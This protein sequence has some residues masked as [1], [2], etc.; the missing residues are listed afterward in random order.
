[1]I[2]RHNRVCNYA[3]IFFTF[4]ILFKANNVYLT[5]ARTDV[6]SERTF[7][8][9]TSLLPQ[10][11][12]CCIENHGKYI[13][14]TNVF[15]M[16]ENFEWVCRLGCCDRRIKAGHVRVYESGPL[17]ACPQQP[18]GLSRKLDQQFASR[19]L[20]I[21]NLVAVGGEGRY[22]HSEARRLSFSSVWL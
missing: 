6:E 10:L 2:M 3:A 21:S 12:A 17:A 20:L 1:M 11:C 8:F 22:F 18:R 16:D 9:L 19:A 7:T 14:S 15:R 13:S 4:E 5:R